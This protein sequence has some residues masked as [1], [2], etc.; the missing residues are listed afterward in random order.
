MGEVEGGKKI[1]N[2]SVVTGEFAYIN[3]NRCF[4]ISYLN[5]ELN[6]QKIYEK[7][8]I[9]TKIMDNKIYFYLV[10]YNNCSRLGDVFENYCRTSNSVRFSFLLIFAKANPLRRS[11]IMVDF[12]NFG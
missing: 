7:K 4:F 11:S 6:I 3:I 1:N 12:W 5:Y 2:Y 8:K 9:I 10:Q